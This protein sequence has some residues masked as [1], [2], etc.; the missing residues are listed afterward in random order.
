MSDYVPLRARTD[1]VAIRAAAWL[2]VES[3]ISGLVAYSSRSGCRRPHTGP[4][5]VVVIAIGYRPG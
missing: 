1:P 3:N 5:G 2:L 4:E